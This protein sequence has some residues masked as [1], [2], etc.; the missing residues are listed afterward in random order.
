MSKS[1]GKCYRWRFAGSNYKL[2]LS[3]RLLSIRSMRLG[4]R[5][6]VAC[7]TEGADAEYPTNQHALANWLESPSS[8]P[9]KVNPI[10]VRI[11]S[12]PLT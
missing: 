7:E 5:L 10:P 1:T 4:F 3:G 11:S 2:T 6:P 12:I 8:A 9:L